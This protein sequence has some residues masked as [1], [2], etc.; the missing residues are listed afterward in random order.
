MK[1]AVWYGRRDV[2]IEDIPEPSSPGPGEVKLK[3]GWCGI[4]GTDLH[5][6]A[7]GPIFTQV[8]TPHPLSGRLAPLTPGHE[9]AGTVV[10]MGPGVTGFSVGDRVSPNPLLRC[11]EC[12]YCKQGL[13]HLCTAIGFMGCHSDGGFGEYVNVNVT[14]GANP[15]PVLYKL[16]DNVSLEVGAMVEP[17]AVGVH[18]TKRGK[19]AEG[20]SVVIVGAGPIGICTTL[21]AKAAKAGQ[22]IVLEP[23]AGR[24]AFAEEAGATAVID[25]KSTDA[26]KA[27]QDLTNGLGADCS[28]EC[29][30]AEAPLKLALSTLR[31]DGRAVV[32]GIFEHPAAADYFDIVFFEKTI[33]G[34]FAYRDEFDAVIE[35]LA[36]GRLQ[37]D[38]MV[39]GRIGLPDLVAGGF[40]ELLVNKEQNVKILVSPA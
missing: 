38:P 6:Y 18:A 26:V 28:F 3:V 31:K 33:I 16:P 10:E 35:M 13:P 4:C 21:A 32:I 25:P 19:L 5:E 27:V 17:L 23:A 15:V 2:R 7:A 30:G 12:A 36:D 29:V 22:I 20:E 8:N 1:A 14:R 40:E 24:R 37:P 39:T 11:G 34:T 9:F